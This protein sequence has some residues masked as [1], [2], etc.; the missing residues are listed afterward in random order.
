MQLKEEDA[1]KLL[2]KGLISQVDFDKMFGSDKN[3]E[4]RISVSENISN[5]ESQTLANVIASKTIR[6]FDYAAKNYALANPTHNAINEILKEAHKFEDQEGGKKL[7]ALC[8]RLLSFAPPK[9]N[10]EEFA[11]I[12]KRAFRKSNSKFPETTEKKYK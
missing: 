2:E 12:V 9:T 10:Q 3:S 5:K 6:E 4:I 8:Y 7:V 11:K 1:R